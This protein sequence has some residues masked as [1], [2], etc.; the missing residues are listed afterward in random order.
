VRNATRN[1]RSPSRRRK[2]AIVRTVINLAI[3]VN[4][5]TVTLPRA[6]ADLL[7]CWGS[8]AASSL[9]LAVML[10]WLSYLR[11][12]LFFRSFATYA[13]AFLESDWTPETT[14]GT[15]SVPMPKMPAAINR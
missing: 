15:N 14:G 10:Y 5:L 6:P 8:L 7:S 13:G 12:V 3:V 9:I 11:K 4:T 1:S 2:K